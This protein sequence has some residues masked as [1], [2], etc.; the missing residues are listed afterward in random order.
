MLRIITL[1]HTNIELR[2]SNNAL[3][4][5]SSDIDALKQENERLKDHNDEL[6]E[7]IRKYHNIKDSLEERIDQLME[8]IKKKNLEI[9]RLKF[10]RGNATAMPEVKEQYEQYLKKTFRDYEPTS[11]TAIRTFGARFF[12]DVM[13]A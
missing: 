7:S 11:V 3:Q 5:H 8:I 6:K 1:N 2:A 9:E 13:Q 10:N 4:V 12:H